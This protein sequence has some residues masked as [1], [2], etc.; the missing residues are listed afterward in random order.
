MAD[1]VPTNAGSGGAT[2]ADDD[3]SSVLYQRLKL[4][5]GADGTNEG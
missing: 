4:I 3:I 2:I 1:N 5:F